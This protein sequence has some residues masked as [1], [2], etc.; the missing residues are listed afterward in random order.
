MVNIETIATATE[1]REHL[2]SLGVCGDAAAAIVRETGAARHAARV[3]RAR[4]TALAASEDREGSVVH[5][6]GLLLLD[7]LGV[8]GRDGCSGEATARLPALRDLG[9]GRKHASDG[10]AWTSALEAARRSLAPVLWVYP[11][12]GGGLWLRRGG[13][14]WSRDGYILDEDDDVIKNPFVDLDPGGAEAWVRAALREGLRR[15]LGLGGWHQI[16]G[17]MWARQLPGHYPTPFDEE[18]AP[19]VWARSLNAIE[20]RIRAALAAEEELA[21]VDAAIV[22]ILRTEGDM[23]PISSE[24]ERELL[25]LAERLRAEALST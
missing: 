5:A 24:Q 22:D 18:T 8:G 10:A 3:E 12:P 23:G 11:D 1:L 20:E 25:L 2:A 14:T 21:T 4:A 16:E 6:A 7:T 9:T 17:I 19:A 13:S 15:S